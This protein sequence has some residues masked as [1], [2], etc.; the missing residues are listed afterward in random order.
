MRAATEGNLPPVM[1]QGNLVEVLGREVRQGS[2][3][4]L[5]VESS[6]SRQRR[7]PCKTNK[8]MSDEAADAAALTY[9]LTHHTG[10][11]NSS[12]HPVCMGKT[13]RPTATQPPITPLANIPTSTQQT[14]PTRR[15]NMPHNCIPRSKKP[16]TESMHGKWPAASTKTSIPPHWRAPPTGVSDTTQARTV[17]G[18]MTGWL[19][20]AG[21]RADAM[22]ISNGHAH[23][24]AVARLNDI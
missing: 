15:P 10:R 14:A 19:N 4:E 6:P 2:P 24:R 12:D 8:E 20:P 1:P 13:G 9:L 16:N 7:P 5:M 11:R 18:I 21:S 17:A 3:G 22:C 23:T